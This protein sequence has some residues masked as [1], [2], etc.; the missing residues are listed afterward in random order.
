MGH[1][2]LICLFFVFMLMYLVQNKCEV[3]GLL[4]LR[5][6]S[7]TCEDDPNWSVDTKDGTKKC[8]D[9][10]NPKSC[11]A[12]EIIGRDAWESCS[13]T[14]GT[15]DDATVTQSDPNVLP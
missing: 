12:S 15:C 8:S 10:T 13:K 9:I 14:C 1:N 6:I 2:K 3:E 11:Y 4:S 7:G 5:Q